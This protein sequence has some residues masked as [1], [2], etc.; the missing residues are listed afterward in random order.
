MAPITPENLQAY[1]YEAI[2]AI[3]SQLNK[4]EALYRVAPLDYTAPHLIHT[5]PATGE[6]FQRNAADDASDFIGKSNE[7]FFGVPQRG[8][9]VEGLRLER[10]SSSQ[11][12]VYPGRVVYGDSNFI[13]DFFSANT[14]AGVVS[15]P[16]LNRASQRR[17]ERRGFYEATGGTGSAPFLTQTLNASA[18][19]RAGTGG[20]ETL[21]DGF[22]GVILAE[23]ASGNARL[24][25]DKRPHSGSAA[26]AF[27]YGN[28][29]RTL[30]M[31]T[32][33]EAVTGLAR[34]GYILRINGAI[35]DFRQEGDTFYLL[36]QHNTQ[37][38]VPASTANVAMY[39]PPQCEVTFRGTAGLPDVSP[40]PNIIT[41][42][43]DGLP[44]L[45][46][47]RYS[48]SEHQEPLQE[49]T[50]LTKT[51]LELGGGGAATVNS[52]TPHRFGVVQMSRT[53]SYFQTQPTVIYP[54]RW[55]DLRLDARSYI[56]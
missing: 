8:V 52:A 35:A 42:T 1:T 44:A 9:Q 56:Y 51:A 30:W 5:D 53:G 39:A 23:D 34:L 54:V 26:S 29:L 43:V 11:I 27:G 31:N 6:I 37:L 12:G 14:G 49:F 3:E 7:M 13:A 24:C 32:T 28:P 41:V 2:A 36:G 10:V 55:R 20:T 4:L 40:L 47:A 33:N 21:D 22:Y 25:F 46:S 38:Q 19:A 17:I 18:I 16:V 50:A 15:A 48:G 45:R